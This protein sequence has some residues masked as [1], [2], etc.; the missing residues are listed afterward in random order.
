MSLIF[1]VATSNHKILL[2]S[3]KIF[4][5]NELHFVN[6]EKTNSHADKDIRC[7]ILTDDKQT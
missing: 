4:L 2:I 7:K 3:N 5:A 1:Q 6:Y